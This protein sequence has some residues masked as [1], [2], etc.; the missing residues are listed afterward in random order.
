[1]RITRAWK[2]TYDGGGFELGPPKTKK[3]VRII[4]VPRAV[5]DKLDYSIEWIFLNR[6]AVESHS[7][8]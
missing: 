1:V 5:L 7:T 4:N 2:R 3:S 6:A 8:G